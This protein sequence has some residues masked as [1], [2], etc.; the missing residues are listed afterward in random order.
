M[1]TSHEGG[2]LCGAVRFRVSGEPA[3]VGIC[4]CRTCQLRTGGAFSVSV[5]F[6]MD[7]VTRLSGALQAYRRRSQSENEWVIERCANCGTSV[8][9]TIDGEAWRGLQGTAGGCYDPPTFW[10]DVTRELFTRS[11]ADFC[12]IEAPEHHDTHPAYSPNSADPARLDG[13]G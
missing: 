2:C 11:K 1:A 5:Y 4:H 12:T 13:A 7:K 8:F 9:W 3:R 10:Y 6:E